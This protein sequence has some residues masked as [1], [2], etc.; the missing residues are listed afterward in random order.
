M[1]IL[2]RKQRNNMILKLYFK[3]VYMATKFSRYSY[4][5]HH[6]VHFIADRFDFFERRMNNISMDNDTFFT[7][8]WI[9][10]LFLLEK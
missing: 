7:F 1:K 5:A 8:N 6:Q 3:K 10:I 4:T 2:T 9:I